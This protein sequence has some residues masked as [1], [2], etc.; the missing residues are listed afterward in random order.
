MSLIFPLCVLFYFVGSGGGLVCASRIPPQDNM[1][2]AP[3]TR[4]VGI[5][6]S[7][8]FSLSA[9][10]LVAVLLIACVAMM[11]GDN[12]LRVTHLSDHN[13]LQWATNMK[14]YLVTK[15]MWSAV[16]GSIAEAVAAGNATQTQRNTDAQARGYLILHMKYKV[17]RRFTRHL[18]AKTVWDSVEEHFQEVMQGEALYIQ[19]KYNAARQMENEPANEFAARVELLAEELNFM[20]QEVSDEDIVNKLMTGAHPTYKLA[21][22]FMERQPVTSVASFISVMQLDERSMKFNRGKA[23]PSSDGETAVGFAA[24]GSAAPRSK[25]PKG[26][27]FKP[28]GT[29]VCVACNKDGHIA[30]NCPTVRCTYC[31]RGGHLEEVCKQ[32]YDHNKGSVSEALGLG[33]AIAFN[34]QAAPSTSA[35]ANVDG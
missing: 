12:D 27:R 30:R 24:T 7:Y 18:T 4:F 35:D 34:A 14:E 13:Y 8:G 33:P 6:F 17:Q 28:D 21:L 31:G 2:M 15:N 10:F 1:V 32:K 19:R 29:P 25:V 5:Q 20:G 11:A 23:Q 22:A 16:E 9:A 26:A 3:P